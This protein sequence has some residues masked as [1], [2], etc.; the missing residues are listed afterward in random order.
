MTRTR[1]VRA[2]RLFKNF[3]SALFA[4]AEENPAEEE[5]R[6]KVAATLKNRRSPAVR[7]G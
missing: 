3:F 4:S 2:K 1:R 5:D 7:L 6:D